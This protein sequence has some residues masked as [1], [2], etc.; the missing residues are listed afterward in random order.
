MDSVDSRELENEGGCEANLKRAKT[1]SEINALDVGVD[2]DVMRSAATI[3]QSFITSDKTGSTLAPTLTSIEV[4]TPTMP[5]VE[6]ASKRSSSPSSSSEAVAV[7][8]GVASSGIY[9]YP[10]SPQPLHLCPQPLPLCPQ[11]S[12]LC[13]PSLPLCPHLYLSVPIFTSLF[14]TT[15]SLFLISTSF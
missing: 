12:P 15:T 8:D 14:S 7:A 4:S 5:K 11:P 6:V 13:S 2:V 1:L 9:L 10:L 3:R